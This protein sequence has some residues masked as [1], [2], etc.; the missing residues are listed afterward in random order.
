MSGVGFYMTPGEDIA[1][2][3]ATA[4]TVIE[5]TAGANHRAILRKLG[6]Y[7]DGVIVTGE[8]VLV[9]AIRITTTGTGTAEAPQK[10]DADASETLQVDFKSNFTVEPT[11][12]A[13]LEVWKVHP[14]GGYA[15][16]MPI[17]VNIPISGGDLWGLRMTAPA[18]VNVVVTVRGE[19]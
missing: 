14:Q 17:D 13:V 19:E 10:V 11:V 7:F 8:S 12:G 4:K 6:F 2:V 5:I 1:L 9:E 3:A 18:A 15:E 16:F